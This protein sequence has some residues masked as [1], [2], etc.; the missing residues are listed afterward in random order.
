MTKK[1]SSLFVFAMAVSLLPANASTVSLSLQPTAGPGSLFD[2]FVRVTSVFDGRT[3]DD[4]VLAYG[5]NVVVGNPSIVFFTGSDPGALFTDLSGAFA[6]VPQVA[7]FATNPF[8]VSAADFTGPLTLAVLHFKALSFGA[9]TVGINYDN[10]DPNQGLV[11]L[12]LPYGAIAASA[13]VTVIPEPG[14]LALC[15]LMIG[16][17]ACAA[18]RFW[19]H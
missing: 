9:T 3:P 18:R 4:A 1:S 15:G 19:K 6:G 14:T 2:V 10:L 12:N 5:F 16:A 8:G 13:V 7:G 17:V 11:Y